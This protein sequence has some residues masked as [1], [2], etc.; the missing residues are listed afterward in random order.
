MLTGKPVIIRNDPGALALAAKLNVET[1]LD[2][3]GDKNPDLG[4]RISDVVKRGIP[5]GLLHQSTP[6][7]QIGYV[8]H[9]GCHR[10][11]VF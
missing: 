1:L 11:N 7:C 8:E 9:T 10:L 6:G 4:N 3:C 5:V 2:M